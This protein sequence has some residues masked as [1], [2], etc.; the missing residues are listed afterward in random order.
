M[1][2][3]KSSLDDHVHVSSKVRSTCITVNL[4]LHLRSHFKYARSDG[5]GEY[6]H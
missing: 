6:V 3:N 5:S 1:H 2:N 4:S